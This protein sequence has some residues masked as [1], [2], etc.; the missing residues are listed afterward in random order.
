MQ[1][2]DRFA[3]LLEQPAASIPLDE[4]AFLIAAHAHPGLDVGAQL[5]R[6]DDLAARCPDP[7]RDGVLAHLFKDEGF[8]GNDAD[9]YDPENSML[10]TVLDRRTGIPITLSVVLIEVARRVGVTLVGVGAPGHFLVGDPSE[11]LLIDAFNGGR[12]LQGDPS[13]EQAGPVAI[14]SRMLGNLKGIY[15][16]KGD[17]ESLR[18]VIRL[19]VLLPDAPASERTELKRLLAHL[20]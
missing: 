7:T 18:W 16:Q 6:L 3:L 12:L 15:L 11:R 8:R 17:V 10:D 19:R 9:Y 1:P 2:T 13:A 20:N 14:V 4:M 5:A